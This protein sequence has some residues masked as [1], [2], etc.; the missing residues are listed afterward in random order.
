[1]DQ[2]KRSWP[3]WK[4][5]KET[6]RHFMLSPLKDSLS[7]VHDT[8]KRPNNLVSLVPWGAWS[9]VSLYLSIFSGIVVGLQY[10]YFT[11]FYSTV[12]LDTLVPFGD[13]FRSLHFYSSQLCFLLAILHFI[14]VFRAS[15]TYPYKEWSKLICS[16]FLLLFLLFTGYVLKSDS[17]GLAA[18]AI[19]E[20]LLDEIPL[21]G[22]L[23]NETFFAITENGLRKVYIQHVAALDAALFIFLWAHLRKYRIAI[24]AH[25]SLLAGVFLFCMLIPAPLDPEKTGTTYISG[26]W[27]FLGLQELL[28][29]LPP[30]IAGIIL[31]FT[32]FLLLLISSPRTK[33]WPRKIISIIAIL[34]LYLVLSVIAWLR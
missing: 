5:K 20:N 8:G 34:T 28:R 22:N 3:N 11:P 19:A 27:F 12:A 33:N 18:G 13:F 7:G 9:L 17:T 29:Y 15:E 30:L 1:M 2:P 4:S 25:A 6:Q 16:L 32:F 26:P 31:P 14:I 23:L 24:S 21:L 10:D